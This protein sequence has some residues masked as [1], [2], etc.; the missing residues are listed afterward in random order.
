MADGLAL[1]V[2]TAQQAA[3]GSQEPARV[4]VTGP[5]GD[6]LSGLKRVGIIAAV[7]AIFYRLYRAI[8]RRG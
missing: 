7:A 1:L 4:A 5:G 8:R 6:R 2:A 3:P